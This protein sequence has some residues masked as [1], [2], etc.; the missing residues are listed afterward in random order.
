MD[1]PR[2]LEM[3]YAEPC[4][5]FL[6]GVFWAAPDSCQC[7]GAA[8]HLAL[9]NNVI[10]LRTGRSSSSLKTFP[11]LRLFVAASPL[12]L[13]VFNLPSV[14]ALAHRYL[15]FVEFHDGVVVVTVVGLLGNCE[16]GALEVLG[17]LGVTNRSFAGRQDPCRTPNA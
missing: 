15:N 16:M 2:Y 13:V 5:R 9:R 14:Y 10:F 12:P 6:F 17:V 7:G 11:R 8:P 4:K 3:S 1:V